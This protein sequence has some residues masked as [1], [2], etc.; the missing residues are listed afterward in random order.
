[1]EKFTKVNLTILVL[2]AIVLVQGWYLVSNYT[3][4]RW[5][6]ANQAAVEKV[7]HLQTQA[8][9]AVVSNLTVGQSK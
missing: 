1:M 7:S 2:V 5:A 3:V 9:D 6:V 4:I 8:T